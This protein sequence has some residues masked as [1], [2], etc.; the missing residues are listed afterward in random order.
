[1]VDYTFQRRF[2]L[3]NTD[4]NRDYLADIT[5]MAYIDMSM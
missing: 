4:N 2:Q 1:M 5:I 3:Q